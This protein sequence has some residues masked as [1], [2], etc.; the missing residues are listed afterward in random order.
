[1][2]VISSKNKISN[3]E[4]CCVYGCKSRAS[5][6]REISF[7]KFPEK[8]KC[9]VEVT[10]K[11]GTIEKIDKRK[12]WIMATR[13]GEAVTSRMRIC[14]LHFSAS[15]YVFS[16]KMITFCSILFTLFI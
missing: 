16:G 14:S 1:M 13:T 10:N 3:H 8:G 11:F 15:D 12:A 9:T 7:H 5:N 4:Y 6:N 2:K